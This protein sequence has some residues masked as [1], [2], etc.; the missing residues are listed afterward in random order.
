MTPRSL[1]D[2][3]LLAALWGGSFLFMR[4]AVPEFGAIALIWVRASV[5]A[6]CLL[7]V[8][9]WHGQGGLLRKQAG[10]LALMGVLSAALPYVL[11]AWAMLSVTSGFASIINATTPIFT[12]L[13]A[14]VWLRE[15]LSRLQMLGLI[16]G[17]VGVAL[18]AADKADFKPGG[19]GWAIVAMLLAAGLYGYSTNLTQR[20][21]RGLPPLVNAAGS[22]LASALA[23]LPLAWWFWPAQTPGLQAWLSVLALGTASTALALLLFFRLIR[24][25]GAARAITVTFLIPV[26]GV[27]WGSLFLGETVTASMLLGGGVIVLGTALATG[28]IR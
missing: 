8:L 15:R 27:L 7:P 13:I 2:L 4:Q 17:L 19:S 28:V 25:V 12:A 16:T 22:Q 26:F 21:L 5:A 18:L 24:T 14:A 23:L 1:F 10:M 6:A 11:I 3:I 9:W 20:Y